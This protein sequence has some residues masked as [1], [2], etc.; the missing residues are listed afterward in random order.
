MFTDKLADL[1]K[2]TKREAAIKFYLEEKNRWRNELS[3]EQ[4]TKLLA[5]ICYYLIEKNEYKKV[6]ELIAEYRKEIDKCKDKGKVSDVLLSNVRCLCKIGQMEDTL[7]ECAH[8]VFNTCYD[9]PTEDKY[10][11][12]S[13]RGATEYAIADI[14]GF[15]MSFQ[16]P[17]E[18][19]DPLDTLLFRW[20]D[21]NILE[22]DY[23]YLYQ[24][25]KAIDHLRVR[26]FTIPPE[27]KN[28]AEELLLPIE[29]IHPLMWAHYADRHHGLCIVYEIKKDFFSKGIHEPSF[30]NIHKVSYTADIPNLSSDININD[31][32][33]TKGQIW[34]YENEVRILD[35]D[36]T[37]NENVKVI[38]L[39]QDEVSIKEVYF[40]V[41]CSE[42]TKN[43]VKKSLRS[44]PTKL[45]Q[46]EINERNIRTL[47]ARRIG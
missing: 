36:M 24:L 39:H 44:K 46:M 12:Y 38:H 1:G 4:I 16:H 40:G 9:I 28:P 47:K 8:Y 27:P 29:R 19:N 7:T 11:V 6:T 2:K 33:F 32:L 45:F 18:F 37:T 20:I 43:M 35:F 3:E 13:F 17:S 15:T 5:C 10:I 30:R 34:E 23:E 41:N 26:C 25:R 21:H 42:Y 14:T 22:G 31:A